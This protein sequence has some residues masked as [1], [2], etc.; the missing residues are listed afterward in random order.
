M[1]FLRNGM[2]RDGLHWLATALAAD[3]GHRPTH[4]DLARYYDAAGDKSQAE[5]HRTFLK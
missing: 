1:I 2:T 5:Y 4:E 3:P